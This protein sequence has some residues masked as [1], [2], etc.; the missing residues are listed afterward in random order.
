VYFS[1]PNLALICKG[2][3]HGA[4][5]HQNCQNSSILDMPMPQL[6]TVYTDQAEIWNDAIGLFMRVLSLFSA[7]LSTLSPPLPL[8]PYLNPDFPST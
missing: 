8:L 3:E 5:K 7:P 4:P 2:H 1:E 6:A